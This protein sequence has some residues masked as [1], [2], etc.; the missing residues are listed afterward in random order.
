MQWLGFEPQIRLRD[1]NTIADTTLP[2]AYF[3][4][5]VSES[6]ILKKEAAE[7]IAAAL[8]EQDL[9][10]NIQAIYQLWVSQGAEAKNAVFFRCTA[11]IVM[12]KWRCYSKA[13]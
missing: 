5:Y 6:V 9:K 7:M 11:F 3:Q 10:E 8:N 13:D 12:M 2:L 4:Q 1:S